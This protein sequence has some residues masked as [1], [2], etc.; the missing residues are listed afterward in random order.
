M[1]PSVCDDPAMKTFLVAATG[2]KLFA[3]R[4]DFDVLSMWILSRTIGHLRKKGRIAV[5]KVVNR[6]F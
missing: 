3:W 4:H 1:M 6:V 2:A 5:E